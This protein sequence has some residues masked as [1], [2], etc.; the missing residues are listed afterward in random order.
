MDS[1]DPHELAADERDAVLGS[2]GVGVLAFATSTDDPPHSLPVSYGYDDDTASVYF[3]LAV[4]GDS[5]KRTLLDNPVSFTVHHEGEDGYESVVVQG[6]L[7]AIEEADVAGS[8]LDG[9][10]RVEIPLFDVFD[11]RPRETTFGFYRLDAGDATG[12]RELQ[13]HD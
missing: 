5:S 6:T 2:G 1:S 3:R 13:R 4:G 11:R 12:K 8:V 7:D 10:S 9:L